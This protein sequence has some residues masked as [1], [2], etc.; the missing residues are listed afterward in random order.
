MTKCKHFNI[1][2]EETGATVSHSYKYNP[3]KKTIDESY[4][5]CEF[6]DGQQSIVCDDCGEE[7]KAPKWFENY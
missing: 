2:V 1:S 7:I 4:E 6:E 3:V 5:G